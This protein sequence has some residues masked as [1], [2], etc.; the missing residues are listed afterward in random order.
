VD[1]VLLDLDRAIEAAETFMSAARGNG[2]QGRFLIVAGEADAR[3]SALAIR[4][5]ASGV[6]LKSESPNRLVQAIALVANGAA[7]LDQKMIR[8][9]A[10][11]SVDRLP[12]R[13]ERRST[14][15]NPLTEREQKVILGILG[16]LTNKKIGEKLGISEG[17]VKSSVQQLFHRTGVRNRSQLVRA[18]LEGSLDNANELTKG[19]RHA[20]EHADPPNSDMP[21]GAASDNLAAFHQPNS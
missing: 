11:Q 12:Q 17:S 2:Y 13:G 5:G 21:R 15:S 19:T 3:E 9:L 6:F 7:W 1:V 18:A 8:L 14:R 20:T 4:L 10:D 16:G